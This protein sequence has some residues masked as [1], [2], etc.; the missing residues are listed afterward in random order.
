MKEGIL[1]AEDAEVVAEERKGYPP[2][3]LR[4]PL[5]HLRLDNR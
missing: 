5:R 1:T 2:R 4:K 3:P